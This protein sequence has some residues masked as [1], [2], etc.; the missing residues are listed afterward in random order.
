MSLNKQPTEKPIVLLVEDEADIAHILTFAL[1]H[2]GCTVVHVDDGLKAVERI[3]TMLPPRLILLDI[4]L[5]RMDGML[6]IPYIRSRPGWE[7]V[8]IVMLTAKAGM[9]D[10]Y[11]AIDSGATSYITKP[12][13]PIELM[14]RLRPFLSTSG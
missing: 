10:V 5:P 13:Q 6:V 3:R 7:D 2:E 1:E 12:F 11:R 14:A 9:E 8:P 4:M